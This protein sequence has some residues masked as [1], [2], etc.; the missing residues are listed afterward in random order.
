MSNCKKQL[1]QY[2]NGE[3][4]EFTLPLHM[5][6]SEF[7]LKVWEALLKIPYGNTASYKDIAIETGNVKAVRAV[8]GACHA[9]HIAIVVPCHRV[10]GSDGSMTGYGGGIEKKTRLL[11]LEKGK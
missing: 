8:A 4:R 2:F 9:N 7:Q 3:R 6:G 5:T 10:I 1:E 11:D